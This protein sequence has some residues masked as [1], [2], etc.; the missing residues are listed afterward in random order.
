MRIREILA[1]QDSGQEIETSLLGVLQFLRNRSREYD[2]AA[3]VNTNSLINMVRKT[4]VPFDYE[5]L[6]SVN[7]S[8]PAVKNLIASMSKDE[9]KLKPFAG[10][11]DAEPD[12][13]AAAAP[14]I[15]PEKKIDAMAKRALAKRQ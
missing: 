5:T 4:G 2:E 8:M 3:T 6:V 7:D 15:D 14:N 11:G 1:E 12:A 10:E 9:I 13:T